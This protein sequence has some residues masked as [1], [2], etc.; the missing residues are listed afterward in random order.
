MAQ[1]TREQATHLRDVKEYAEKILRQVEYLDV[2]HFVQLDDFDSLLWYTKQA[3]SH[4]THA[5]AY[6]KV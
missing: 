4:A 2:K 5:A 1:L 3:G 6:S